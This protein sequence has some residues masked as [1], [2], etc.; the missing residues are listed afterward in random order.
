MPA[1]VHTHADEQKWSKAK[2]A[3][4][5][6]GGEPNWRLA[7]YIFHNMKKGL[8]F[9]EALSKAQEDI[10]KEPQEASETGMDDG[11]K[12]Y[13]G[14]KIERAGGLVSPA[15]WRVSHDDESGA[16]VLHPT[17]FQGEREA[18]E[19]IDLKHS[20]MRKSQGL[21]FNDLWKAKKKPA[22]LDPKKIQGA[23]EH[24]VQQA[25]SRAHASM[26]APSTVPPHAAK[27]WGHM[28]AAGH[29][30][31][32][33]ALANQVHEGHSQDDA[34]G[35]KQWSHWDRGP[36][37]PA[38]AEAH[39]RIGQAHI[40]EA[41]RISAKHPD[42]WQHMNVV[43]PEGRMLAGP[44]ATAMH[45]HGEAHKEWQ[46][47][48]SWSLHEPH[49]MVQVPHQAAAAKRV[50]TEQAS[51]HVLDN[52]ETHADAFA[53]EEGTAGAL[54]PG[55]G[56]RYDAQLPQISAVHQGLWGKKPEGNA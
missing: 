22:N 9:D 2:E 38:L 7:N 25:H 10:A 41:A 34:H 32:M 44:M 43:P 14:Y 42:V 11:R 50:T 1:F 17:E 4:G 18:R 40:D 27:F 46:G 56:H 53:G 36:N 5:K 31:H 13:R 35:G 48:W 26:P 39:S 33:M 54:T 55:K 52:A 30:A 23:M 19:Y 47:Q 49:Q 15:T 6:K 16:S 20:E 21:A 45:P 24:V 51:H 37:Y 28:E 12:G 29:H 3:A 8:G